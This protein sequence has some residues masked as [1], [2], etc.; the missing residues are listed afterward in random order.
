MPKRFTPTERMINRLFRKDSMISDELLEEKMRSYS[1][2]SL[3]Y[4]LLLAASMIIATLGLLMDA[5]AI[6]IGSMIISPLTWPM[7]GL[8]DG[9]ALGNRKRIKANLIILVGSILFG[10]A[11][12]YALTVLSPLKVINEEILSRSRPTLLDAIV[13]LTAGGIGI[14]AI[15]RKNISD[16]VAGVAVA[17]SLTPP[18]C[19]VGISL[20][21]SERDIVSGSFL[22]LVTNALSITLIAGLILVLVHYSWR[23]KL[24][25]APR[26]FAV[27][28]VSLLITAIPLYQL[29]TVYSLESSSYD[30]VQTELTSYI[31]G[32]SPNGSVQ[33]IRTDLEDN[34]LVVDADIFLPSSVV[35]TFEDKDK[36]IERLTLL[37]E[38]DVDLRLKVQNVSLLTSTS[39]L[40]NEKTAQEL[41]AS[42]RKAIEDL[43][44]E[45]EINDIDVANTI[46]DWSINAQLSGQPDLVPSEATIA[47]ISSKLSDQFGHTVSLSVSYLPLTQIKTEQQT[48]AESLRNRLQQELSAR[49]PGSE[50]DSLSFSSE[51]KVADLKLMLLNSQ[52]IDEETAASLKTIITAQIPSVT[53]LVV[54]TSIFNEVTY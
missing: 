29:L 1:K 50:V 31:E 53:S 18:V 8:A 51:Y 52:D 13:A 4:F 39:T 6:V 15:V 37:V 44:P 45:I 16:T 2:F 19:V 22:L 25:M 26:A 24:R 30:T 5:S 20:A 46:K 41:R 33:N 3:S 38:R 17:L 11:I 54:R 36:L 12:A 34:L 7:F 40:E 23:R 42:F 10:I 47:D 27:M 43:N 35:L 21:L 28:L 32:L 14:L 49:Y 9:A 48:Q